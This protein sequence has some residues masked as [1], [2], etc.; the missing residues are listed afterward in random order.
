MINSKLYKFASSSLFLRFLRLSN[1]LT[2][3]VSDKSAQVLTKELLTCVSVLWG[4]RND[5]KFSLCCLLPLNIEAL[6]CK[7]EKYFKSK[8][9]RQSSMLIRN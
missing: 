3:V 9:V 4:M 2:L 6:L 1:S 8:K 5:F 7:G